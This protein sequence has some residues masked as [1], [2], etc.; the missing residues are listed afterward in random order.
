MLLAERMIDE[1]QNFSLELIKNSRLHDL[2]KFEPYEFICLWPDNV[3]FQSA[4]K[5]HRKHNKHHPEYWGL[6]QKMP[7]LYI[8]EMVCDCF[9][10]SQEFGTSVEDW[11]KNEATNKYQFK[12]DD[13]VGKKIQKY[14]S[15]LTATKF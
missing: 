13:E 6:I 9:A 4:L 7:D 12:W 11:F 2:S 14:L 5:H 1:G 15:I 8:A 3:E 10:R